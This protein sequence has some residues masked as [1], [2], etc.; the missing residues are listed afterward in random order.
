MVA[1]TRSVPKERV[2]I[3]SVNSAPF[4]DL[5]FDACSIT[6]QQGNFVTVNENFTTLFGYNLDDLKNKKLSDIIHPNDQL[7]FK[8]MI[9]SLYQNKTE[10]HGTIEVYCFDLNGKMHWIEWNHKYTNGQLY[11]VGRD[12][13]PLKSYRDSLQRQQK[14]LEEAEAIGHIGQWEWKVGGEKII[15]SNQLYSIF[16]IEKGKFIPTLQNITR[17]IDRRDSGRMMQVFQR[18]IIEQNDYDMD[19]RFIHPD[20]NTR[21]IRCEGRCEIDQD[22]D[23][24]FSLWNYAG[25]HCCDTA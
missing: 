20:G 9:A 11:S 10:N 21:Y 18:A 13:T 15:F 8:K 19:F 17:M 23:V 16:G 1:S 12:L 5:S 7:T 14:K 2:P 24:V 3:Q 22:D 6:D 25:Y 4:I